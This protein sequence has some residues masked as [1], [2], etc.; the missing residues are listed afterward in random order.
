MLNSISTSSLKEELRPIRSRGR[1]QPG[2]VGVIC[3]LRNEVARLPLF[4]EHY[5]KLGVNRFF[6]VDNAST[7]GSAELLLAEPLAD[8]YWTDASY[9]A[10]YFGIYWYNAIAQAYCRGNW[11]LMADADELLVYDGMEENDLAAFAGLL[12]GRG[13]DRVYAPMI[14]LYTSGAIGER[15]RSVAEIVADDAWF[16]ADGYK[17]ERYPAGWILSGGPRE[18]LFN[19]ETDFRPHWISKYPFLRMSDDTVLFDAH[20]VW[21]WDRRYAG[22]NAALLHLKILDD[23]V[24]RCAILEQENQHDSNSQAYRFINRRLAEI[25]VLHAMYSG[26]R[27]YEGPG[28]LVEEG[29][30]LPLDWR[31]KDATRQRK[32]RSFELPPG[33]SRRNWHPTLPQS[34]LIWNARDEYNDLSHQSLNEH[35]ETVRSRGALAPGDVGAICV[36]RN[37]AARLPVFFDHYKKLGVTRFFM[38]D[39]RSEDAT[40]ELLLAEPTA[41]VFIAH[42]SFNEGHGGLYWANGLARE[43]CRDNWIVRPDADELLVYDGMEKH[44]LSDLADWLSAHGRDRLFS[45]MLDVYPSDAIGVEERSIADILAYDCWFDSEGYSLKKRAGGWLIIG[46]PRQRMMKTTDIEH[47]LSKYP[48]FRVTDETAIFDHH[49]LWPIDWRQQAPAAALLHTKLMDDFVER[50]ARFEREGQHAFDS[51]MYKALNDAI[52][53]AKSVS[54]FHSNSRR[55]RGPQ[56]LLRYRVMQTIDWGK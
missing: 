29:L 16:D 50:S 55:Y 53:N 9:F 34:A 32:R 23:F 5:R 21:P 46:G 36:V 6:M 37:E 2:E 33:T 41:D 22:P 45:L 4:F 49:W 31:T 51:I 39:N 11:I 1:L 13:H 20:F 7:D 42:A 17:V 47:W 27:R 10:S 38:V 52:A 24:E 28:S 48:F 26:S 15:R 14:D 56:S 43:Y 3:V 30:L 12:D 54:F 19:N 25:P 44:C 40:H 8:V 18:R 35:L